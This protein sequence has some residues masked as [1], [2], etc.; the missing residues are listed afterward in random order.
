M[1]LAIIPEFSILGESSRSTVIAPCCIF[2]HKV[3]SEDA[4]L[5]LKLSGKRTAFVF[6]VVALGD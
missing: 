2:K 1:F 4:F 6:A 3:V 5:L